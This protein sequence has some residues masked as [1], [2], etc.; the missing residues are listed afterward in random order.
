M[1][2]GQ[3]M[4]LE[5][6]LV[7]LGEIPAGAYVTHK[8]ESAFRFEVGEGWAVVA[9]VRDDEVFIEYERKGGQLIFTHPTHVFDPSNLS[10]LKKVPAPEDVEEWVS[11]F[12]RHPNLDTSKPAP[13]SVG[14]ASG[15]RIDVRVTSTPG[16][17]PKEV[18][19]DKPCVP[20]YPLSSG[21]GIWGSEGSKDRFVIVDIGGETVLIDVFDAA[22]RFDEFLPKAQEVLDSVEW[23][24][25]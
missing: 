6:E 10:E 22:D 2:N 7:E 15:M 4:P 23:K 5:P 8:F 12:H 1:P 9:P 17:Y 25:G 21:G 18:C 13:A 11:W 24:G 3:K 20:L 16:N 14:D 19:G